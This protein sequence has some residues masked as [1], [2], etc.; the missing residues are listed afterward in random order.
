MTQSEVYSQLTSTL[1]GWEGL[2]KDPNYIRIGNR[3]AWPN[4]QA[5]LVPDFLTRSLTRGLSQA[6]QYTFRVS[7]DD[8]IIQIAY[9]FAPNGSLEAARLAFYEVG[10]CETDADV[11]PLDDGEADD[12]MRWMR[13]DFTASVP[14]QALHASCHLHLSGHPHTRIAL[15]GV[16]NPAQ[17]VEFALSTFYSDDYSAFRLTE[18]GLFRNPREIDNQSSIIFDAGNAPESLL[19]RIPFLRF[20][21]F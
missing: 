8:S 20:P 3:I 18:T 4:Q 5:I 6:G 14:A 9:A 21:G 1:I 17:F 16:P 12:E 10:V 2:I 7:K 13:I 19:R 11:A 15:G